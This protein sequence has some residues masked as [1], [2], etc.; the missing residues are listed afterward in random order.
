MIKLHYRSTWFPFQAQ[1][2]VYVLVTVG[3]FSSRQFLGALQA[4]YSLADISERLQRGAAAGLSLRARVRGGPRGLRRLPARPQRRPPG[5]PPAADD[6]AGGRR[7]SRPGGARL[8]A[9]GDRRTG[10]GLQRHAP[11]PAPEPPRDGGAH[12]LAA[13]GS[14]T[15]CAAP[16]RSCCAPNGWL[17]WDTSPPAWPTRSATRSARSS[18][19]STC[20]GRICATPATSTWPS[21]RWPR[22][23]ASTGWSGTC[24]ILPPRTRR[25]RAAPTRPGSSP[26]RAPC[27]SGRGS[28]RGWNWCTIA[29]RRCRRC[30]SPA[31]SS[32]RLWSTWP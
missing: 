20:C 8:R 26:R 31:T 13:A 2:P 21:D 16:A 12:R 5:E 1:Q 23:A 18:A 11:G 22:P 19:T 10:R 30:R 24:W 3:I 6:P 7:G 27:C 32:S 14:T 17:P 15:S 29:R 28:S 25:S 9:G 4:R